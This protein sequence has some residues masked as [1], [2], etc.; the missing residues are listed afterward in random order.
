MTA[1]TPVDPAPTCSLRSVSKSAT[2]AV[3]ILTA[4]LAPATRVTE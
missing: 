3:G 1:S 4:P 2:S